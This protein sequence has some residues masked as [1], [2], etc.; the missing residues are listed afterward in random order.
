MLH[1]TPESVGI[2]SE[3][4]LK[5]I[6]KLESSN[7]FTH[8]VIIMRHGKIV[9]EAYWEPFHKDF[10]HRMYSISKSFV[11]LAIGFLEQDDKISLDDKLEKYFAKELE[12]QPDANM[13][14]QTIRHTL[15]MST[16]KECSHW[17]ADKPTDRVEYYFANPKTNSR[18]SG[19]FF[20][21]DSTG[22]FVLGALVERITGKTLVDYLR[23]KLFDKIGVSKQAYC[24]KCPGG[25]SW[26]DS[27]FLCTPRDL[28]LIAQF[29]M[30]GG[31]WN[32]EQILNEKFI[33]DATA[34]QIDT[35]YFPTNDYQQQGYGY[36]IWRTFDNSYFFNGMGC[37]F[38]VCVPDKDL[39]FV[40]NADNQGKD[41][42][43]CVIF[44]NF[45]DMIVRTCS[46]GSVDVD[47]NAV[48]ELTE[49]TSNLKLATAKGA[50]SSPITEKINGV[51][52]LLDENS[53]GIKNISFTFGKNGGII[54]YTNEQGEKE[55]TFGMCENVF[56]EFPQDGYADEVGT[57]AGSRRFKC[58]AS[59]AWLSEN[60]LNVY[61]QI[62]DT[63]F[64]QLIMR[65]GFENNK[66]GVYM[67]KN[68]EDFLSE[69]EGFASGYSE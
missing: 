69:Y 23:E 54:H 49:Y 27:A 43:Q 50:N 18:P 32:G 37:Q 53:M 44:D 42:A 17:F 8:D 21:Y 55:I 66:I 38:A 46:D 61:V 60:V 58:A 25:H 30:N 22:S 64:G 10:L 2:K 7:L 65:F 48:K 13:H 63:Y 47:E 45:F 67:R 28:L 14:N 1:T 39:I 11:A 6:K 56:G 5:Y 29:V 59:A 16:A 20:E 68:A 3:N 34:K 15:M 51:N 4:I 35:A 40:Y 52:Y 24:L 31:K 9:Y 36:Q 41:Y 62:I 26:G 19:M 57:Q 33:K 12:T